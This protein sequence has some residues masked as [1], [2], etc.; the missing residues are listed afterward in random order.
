MKWIAWLAIYAA[1]F[2]RLIHGERWSE[3]TLCAA[4]VAL[5]GVFFAVAWRLGDGPTGRDIR[6]R[7][8]TWCWMIG[9]VLLA[10]ATHQVLTVT[11]LGFLSFVAL[12][13]YFSLLPMYHRGTFLRADDRAAIGLAYLTIPITY[14]LA[15]IPWYGLY[16]IFIPVFATLCLPVVMVAADNPRGMLVS[17]G[18]I[19]TGI[20][21]FVYLFSHAVLLV[22]LAPLLLLYA[23]LVTE[24]RDV[25]AYCAGKLLAPLA[26]P[27]AQAAVAPH[28]NPRKTWV[29]AALAAIGCA[30]ASALL[31]PL[32]PELPGGRPSVRFLLGLGFAVGWLGLVGDLAIGAFKRDL[33]VKD[34]GHSLPGHGG[35]IDRINGVVFTVPVIFHLLYYFYYPGVSLP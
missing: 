8:E 2:A 13:E 21:L 15:A 9:V 7:T 12:R 19:L 6:V 29:G 24:I 23:L 3:F 22:H 34:T 30:A 25:L 10:I 35:V 17:L 31:A 28:I 16:I 33:A 5:L 4:V 1:G 18:G 26:A 20:I 32:M 11:L 27:W 14:W